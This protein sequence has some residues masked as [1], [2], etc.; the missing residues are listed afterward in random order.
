MKNNSLKLLAL[1]V[2]VLA[3]VASGSL[4]LHASD[5]DGALATVA[6]QPEPNA[7]DLPLGQMTP[8]NDFDSPRPYSAA[9]AT[10]EAVALSGGAREVVEHARE[11]RISQGI[12]GTEPTGDYPHV[13]Q[14]TMR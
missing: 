8:D 12:F 7:S 11:S 14:A 9:P 5:D 10:N 3:V 2:A 6:Q 13:E 4:P 1:A